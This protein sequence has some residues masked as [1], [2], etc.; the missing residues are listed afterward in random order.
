[1]RV[2]DNNESRLLEALAEMNRESRPA[3]K[4]GEWL[5]NLSSGSVHRTGPPD[6]LLVFAAIN[7]RR[8]TA[9]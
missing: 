6:L 1:M 9:M 3:R 8:I 4:V 5:D 7:R 2:D